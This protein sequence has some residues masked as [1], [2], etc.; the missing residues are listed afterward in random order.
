MLFCMGVK[1]GRVANIAGGKK[2]ED[3]WAHGVEE[4]IW[5]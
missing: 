2:A 3:V 4:N 1:L 5:T